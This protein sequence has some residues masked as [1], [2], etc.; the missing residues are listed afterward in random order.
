MGKITEKNEG[1]AAN[2]DLLRHEASQMPKVDIK[3]FGVY[4]WYTNLVSKKINWWKS[5]FNDNVV[6]KLLLMGLLIFRKMSV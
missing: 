6:K 4:P 5:F 3:N 2:Q 1:T